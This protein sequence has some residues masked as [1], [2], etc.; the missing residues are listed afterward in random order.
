MSYLYNKNLRLVQT[1]KT[2]V[3]EKASFW[4]I[5]EL[6]DTKIISSKSGN[7]HIIWSRLFFLL[8]RPTSKEQAE[9]SEMSAHTFQM[10]V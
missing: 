1:D 3:V 5:Y 10:H 8:T 2:A 7:T 6:M 9:S 4:I